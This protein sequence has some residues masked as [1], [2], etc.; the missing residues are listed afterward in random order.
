MGYRFVFGAS[1]AGKSYFLYREIIEQAEKS[2][3]KP[4]H[5][6]YVVPD[7]YSMQVQK[8]LVAAHPSH[9]IM[10]ID[11][12]SFGR[13]AHRIFE[14]IGMQERP[15]LN[16]MG[17]TLVLRRIAGT[18]RKSL[19]VIGGN[20]HKSGYIAEVKSALSEFM[21]YG[22]GLRELDGLIEYAAGQGALQAR[23][24]D[25]RTLYEAFLDY[26]RERFVTSE[27]TLDLL[28]LAV[29][30]SGLLRDSVIVVDGFTGFTP[31]QNR[32]LCALMQRAAQVSVSLTISQ[33]GGLPVRQVMET[34]DAG[35][36]ESLFYAA[37]KTVRDL[38]RLAQEA[39]VIHERDL[40]LSGGE[41]Q[42][43]GGGAAGVAEVE[44][45]GGS[46]DAA[47]A[48]RPG[49][50]SGAGA[51]ERLGGSSETTV[52]EQFGRTTVACPVRFRENPELAHLEAH[53]FRYPLRPYREEHGAQ[54]AAF[55]PR[56]GVY[57]GENRES[58]ADLE[59]S[60]IRIYE[61]SD[62]EEEARQ[63]C[64]LIRRLVEEEGYCYR[65]FAAVAGDLES[66]ADALLKMSARY[67]I[68]VYIDR[69]SGVSSNPLTEAIRSALEIVLMDFSY[70]SV[71]H[72]LRSGLSDL[73]Q[74][75]TDALEN[76]CL[77]HG[78]RGAKRWDRV[79]ETEVEEARVRFLSEI[80]PLRI[81]V[82][83][84]V[85]VGERVR[86][87]YAFLLGVQ[88]QSKT[89]ESA[90]QFA[91]EGDPVRER[92]YRQLYR[93]VMELLDQIYELL[94]EERMNA[95]DFMEL[96]ETGFGEIRVGTLPQKA[97]RLV[98]G[99][100]ERTR[101]MQVKV[102]FV[103]GVNDGNIPKSASG[104]GLLS[105][106]D[107]EFLAGSGTELA[108]TPRQQMYTQRL[109][110]YLNMTKPTER[111]FLSYA[112]VSADGRT[113]RPSYLIPMIRRMFP[114]TQ[115]EVPEREPAASRL[116]SLRDSL[117]FLA[118]S[119][120][121]F[122]DGYYDGDEAQRRLFLTV[123]GL[124]AVLPGGES[125]AGG[126][127]AGEMERRLSVLTEAAFRR[128]RPQTLRPQT[129]EKLYGRYLRGSVSRLETCAQCYCRQFLQYGMRLRERPEYRFVPT[130]AGN[131]LHESVDKFAGKLRER[132]LTWANFTREQGRQL[133]E[134]VVEESTAAYADLLLY[135]TARSTAAV[136][137][138]K[139]VL[140][141]S[142]ETLQYQLSRGLFV[143]GAYELA[144]GTREAPLG[145]IVLPLSLRDGTEK[146]ALYL[147]GRIDRIDLCETQD[148][149]YVKILDYKSGYR[150]LVPERIRQGLQLQLMVY[151]AAALEMEHA[152]HPEKK[153]VPAAMLYYRF[154]DPLTEETA[155]PEGGRTEQVN[156][157]EPDNQAVPEKRQAGQT[158]P[159]EEQDEAQRAAQRR[160][161]RPRGLVNAD[162]A[163][164][165]LLDR[166]H[167]N[168]SDVIPVGWKKDGSL[169]SS[170]KAISEEEY[171]ELE[172]AAR[173][174]MCRLG[175]EILRGNVTAS[176]S[177]VDGRSACLY[178]PY[179]DVCGFDKKT[180]GY[181]KRTL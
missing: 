52:T 160:L 90:S 37:R 127:V 82:S 141:R 121:Q 78:I 158:A 131:V 31:V 54:D 74:E 1:G 162:E 128:Y 133:A 114:Q 57:G 32:V 134:E 14:E 125:G 173:E 120:R 87:L 108:P 116:R 19:P 130:D 10:N 17:K 168:T 117:P 157:A 152:L 18:I 142:V 48:E 146:S 84:K 136:E 62:P 6:F 154:D 175:E 55:A 11:V 119:L 70:E 49:R 30:Q 179:R 15:V 51:E 107:R 43:S 47:V 76:Y 9:G 21:Q 139:R 69:K 177:I 172:E 181:T 102:L 13:L 4:V 67:E 33:D 23:L 5:F 94:S 164:L 61:A 105:D 72:Y 165:E 36:Q 112:R 98:A 34:G 145:E 20:L 180:P 95:R 163:V 144:F 44:R 42:R 35:A 64:I 16:D 156:Q 151:M 88:A 50:N 169:T 58:G 63:M 111:L 8:E 166:G 155:P 24:R 99:D 178:C 150:D 53:L 103:L 86:A 135:A 2:L 132:G 126:S 83:A 27:E 80:A 97:D 104:G 149:V 140:A 38:S 3:L 113:Q 115:I 85:T 89:E 59:E 110:L 109:A 106:L 159:E 124:G 153:A 161:L 176:P 148:S 73:T 12:L 92:A 79:F 101:L 25:L 143:P 129:A 137:R 174:A 22:V 93:K 77:A 68:P 118:D 167:T 29:P 91:R 7:Q 65:D 96:M 66:Y 75:E 81:A 100:M 60:A 122:A 171:R 123:Y 56:N 170:S 40:Y 46:S 39:G 147:N 28:A 45:S 41:A 26:E 71:F 138:I